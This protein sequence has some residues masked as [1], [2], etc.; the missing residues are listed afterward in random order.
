MHWQGTAL[1]GLCSLECLSMVHC[2]N[3]YQHCLNALFI[4]FLCFLLGHS[5]WDSVSISVLVVK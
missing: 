4:S 5:C 3:R 2:L 1:H